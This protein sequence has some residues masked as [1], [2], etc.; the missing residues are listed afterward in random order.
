MRAR[1]ITA[2]AVMAIVMLLAG[3]AVAQESN[4]TIRTYQGVS[5]KLADLSMEVFYTIGEPKGM[6]GGATQ[7][8]AAQPFGT[9]IT[10]APSQ[11]GAPGGEQPTS[12]GSGEE[13]KLLRGHSQ[14][15][16]VTVSRQGVETRIGW[17]QVRAMRFAR[18]PVSV[19]SLP[20]Y[21][22][23]YRYTATVS[24]VNGQQVEAD[25][26]NLGATVLRG[27]TQN[28][29][30]EIPWQDVEYLVFDR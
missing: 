12:T 17:D 11:G 7:G 6:E 1:M 4:A 10:I 21:V 23:H 30:M 14:A 19:A 24:L 27:M 18:A 25:Y 29:R 8:A 20:P 15:T 3:S 13:K 9:M 16:D 26:V 2:V 28:G 22:P 5:Y